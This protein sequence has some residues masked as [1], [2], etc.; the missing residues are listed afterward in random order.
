MSY[1]LAGSGYVS[2][3]YPTWYE[4]DNWCS[5]NAGVAVKSTSSLK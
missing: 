1:L 2:I 3:F 4:N 5:K